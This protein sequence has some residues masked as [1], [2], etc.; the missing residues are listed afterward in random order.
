MSPQ[1]AQSLEELRSAR[2]LSFPIAVDE[3]NEVAAQFGIRHG[4]PDDLREVYLGFGLDLAVAN[5]ED[6]WTLPMPARFVI[7][8]TGVVQHVAADPD[9]TVRPEPADTLAAV[10]AL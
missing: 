7:D 6:S 1:N 3:G 5:G 2:R 9:Y 8:G 10:R 4:F